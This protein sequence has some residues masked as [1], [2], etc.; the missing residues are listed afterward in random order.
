MAGVQALIDCTRRVKCLIFRDVKPRT[1]RAELLGDADLGPRRRELEELEDVA[2]AHAYA[3]DRSRF[4]HL[5]RV[6]AAVDI[7]ISPHGVHLP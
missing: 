7:D 4:S 6:R 2:V 5:D 1:A 3:P